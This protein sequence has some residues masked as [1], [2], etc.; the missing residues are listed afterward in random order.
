MRILVLGG[1]SFVG[2]SIVTKA[3]D[4]DHDV[5]LFHRGRTGTDL[6]P[7]AERLR[8]DRDEN[9]LSALEG[10]SFDAVVDVSGTVPR[11]VR[12]AAEVLDERVGRYLFLSSNTVYASGAGPGADESAPLVAPEW[13]SEVVGARTRGPLKV[14]CERELTSRFGERATIVRPGVLAGPHDNLDQ[15]TYW[16]RRAAKGG[17]VVLPGDPGQPLQVLDARDLAHLVVRLLEEDRS[18]VFNAMGPA[19]PLTLAGMIHTCAAAAGT[20]VELILVPSGT[21]K[22][23]FPLVRPDRIREQ[24]FQRDTT[25]ARE[26]GL[27]STPLS[28]TA[29]DVLAW[30]RGRGEPPLRSAPAPELERNLLDYVLR[31]RPSLAA[32]T[33][34]GPTVTDRHAL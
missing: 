7:G 18:G 22:A 23:R 8:G 4:R 6:F 30:D 14:A 29:A 3:L 13:D 12:H 11:H 20:G 19:A 26:A 9:D 31:S 25:R 33:P 1:T 17:R 2:R 15:F 10:R 21:V 16:V 27:P 34:P 32:R 28:T 5:T 24:F